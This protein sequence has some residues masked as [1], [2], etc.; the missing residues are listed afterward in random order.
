MKMLTTLIAATALNLP[1][2]TA[3]AVAAEP[4]APAL[5]IEFANI[6]EP[7]GQILVAIYDS[8]AAFD[9]GGKPVRNIAVPV[10]AAS[11]SVTV[12]GLGAGRYGFKLFHDV[13]GDGKMGTNPYGMPIEPFAFS[14]NAVANMGPAKWAAAAF[15]VA[16]ATTQTITFR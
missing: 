1:A 10:D 14:N 5:T 9:R 2:L 13:D 12:D 15:D 16:G 11:E 8:E 6:A 4:V 7:S 3:G